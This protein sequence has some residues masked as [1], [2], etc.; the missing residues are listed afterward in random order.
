MLCP[1]HKE[2]FS[3]DFHIVEM[4]WALLRENVKAKIIDSFGKLALTITYIFVFALL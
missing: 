2:Q 3:V 1:V 4:V